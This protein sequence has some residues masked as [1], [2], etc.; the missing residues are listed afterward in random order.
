[1]KAVEFND[2]SF[3]YQRGGAGLRN[4]ELS[5][6]KGSFT[7]VA[8]PSGAGKT[9]LCMAVNGL[10]PHY[11][12]GSVSGEVLVDSH[13]TLQRKVSDLALVVG[14]VMEDFESQLVAMTVADEI[15]FGLEN[16][17]FSRSEIYQRTTEILSLVGLSGK[18][19]CETGSLSG[20]QKQRLAIAAVLVTDADILVLDEPA[21]ALDPE[22]AYEL[23]ALLNRLNQAKGLTI[24]VVEHDL[25]RVLPY[26]KQLVFMDSGRIV[27][28]GRPELTLAS[29]YADSGY[30]SYVPALQELRLSLEEMLSIRLSDWED[31]QEAI[32]ELD[33]LLTRKRMEVTKS[34]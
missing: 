13:N 27:A 17:G 7:V 22:G 3:S 18:E 33:R 14:T 8:G 34:A 5:I 16:R 6:P 21:S 2:F 30:R 11:F 4:I 26:A 28:A 15:A 1:M 25:A 31:E 32:T 20:G 9:T 10:V 23:Y 12:G 24:V 29:M 19:A